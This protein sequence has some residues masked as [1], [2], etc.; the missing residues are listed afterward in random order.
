MSKLKFSLLFLLIFSIYLFAD[1]ESDWRRNTW[2]GYKPYASY[3]IIDGAMHIYNNQAKYGFG[4]IT[5]KYFDAI[6]GD[7]VAITATV[8]GKGEVAFQLQCYTDNGKKWTGVDPQTSE[9]TLSEDWEQK[10]FSLLVPNLQHGPTDKFMLTFLGKKDTE[11]FIKDIKVKVNKGNYKGD[12]VFPLQWKVFS[13]VSTDYTAPLDNIPNSIDGISGQEISLSSGMISFEKLFAVHKLHNCAWLYATIDAP[14]DCDYTIGAGADYYM[15]VYVNDEVLIDTMKSGNSDFPPHFSNQ[16]NDA[17]LKKGKNIIAIK[18]LTGS[19]QKPAVSLGGAKELRELSQVVSVIKYFEKDDYTEKITRPGNP[20]IIE[21][22][23][24]DGI[25]TRYKFGLYKDGSEITFA[26]KKWS[27]PPKSGDLLFASGLRL[28]RLSGDGTMTFYL[29]DS[30]LLQLENKNSAT[31]IAVTLLQNSAVL[32]EMFYPKTAL[33]VDITLAVGNNELFVNMLSLQDSKLRSLNVKGD[34]SNLQDFS[35]GIR[36]NG[37]TATVNNY[38][39]GLAQREIKSSTVPFKVAVDTSF[40]PVQAGWKLFWQDEFDGDKVDWENKWMNSPWNPVPKNREQAYLKDGML[41]I[42][43]D[44]E[45]T[46]EGP[47][48]FQGKTVGLYSQERFGYGYYEARVRFT[49]KPGWW[50]AF[51]MF[52]EGRNMTVGGGYELDIFEDYSTRRGAPIIAN[53][54]HV[55]YGPNMRSYGYHFELPGSLDD[56]YVIGCKWTPFEFST[57]VNGQLVK[58]SARHSPYNS[59]TYDAI[60]HAFGVTPLYLSISGQAGNSGGTAQEVGSE[61]YLVDY[62][63]AY[64]YPRDR[65]PSIKF[66]SLPEKSIVKSGEEISFEVEVTPSEIS[67]SAIATVY[68]FDN[69]NLLDYKTAPP[70]KFTF[71]IDRK[72]YEN[73][74]WDSVGRSGAKSILD[75]YPHF[76]RAAVQDEAGCVAY[77]D[78]FP[79][80]TD[81]TGGS[82]FDENNIPQVPGEIKAVNFNKGGQNIASYKQQRGGYE[83]AK[84]GLFSRRAMHLREAGEWVTYTVNVKEAGNYKAVL[85]RREYRRDSWSM[86]AVLLADGKYITDLLADVG[87][88][89]AESTQSFKLEKGLQQINIISA[90]TYGVWPEKIEFVKQ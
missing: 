24:T 6:A 44:F 72:S 58:S 66:S 75:G 69:G 40:D 14:Y 55:T 51:W 81:A 12:L 41:H 89:K 31:D 33:P 84:E 7:E 71:S 5:R 77:T 88:E 1:F 74:A 17:K 25:E 64:E 28:Q 47:R 2:D 26:N 61:E 36:L 3:E 27:I 65:D 87:D 21:D 9:N 15:T 70:Y 38:F 56:F 82:A 49:R 20:E 68:L 53:N 54:L 18:F 37:C 50:A 45:K 79:V 73:T 30:L 39:T 60:N 16:I 46:P 35:S 90:C 62:V 43:C 83:N 32:S 42:R 63:R 4:W 80:I 11:L 8:K 10:N 57:Y 86:R 22:I 52:D 34:F 13:G 85:H 78:F 76:F 67:S 23:L 59:A 19:S 48:P 29:S